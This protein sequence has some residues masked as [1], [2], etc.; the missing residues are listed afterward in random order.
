M[1]FIYLEQLVE[2]GNVIGHSGKTPI[3]YESIN[4]ICK[5]FLK[6]YAKKPLVLIQILGW[7]QRLMGYY[8]KVNS[9]SETEN[10]P[11]EEIEST[12]VK[13]SRTVEKPKVVKPIKTKASK[14]LELSQ[15][16]QS[17]KAVPPKVIEPTK[18]E[19]SDVLERPKQ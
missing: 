14:T 11:I 4:E 13:T 5:I 7:S 1:F 9:N 8:K 12:A 10:S 3:Y 15:P 17:P 18:A 19:N 2:Y 16:P 6:V